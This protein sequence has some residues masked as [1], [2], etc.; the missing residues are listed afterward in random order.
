[1]QDIPPIP[2]LIRAEVP[3]RHSTPSAQDIPLRHSIQPL[4]TAHV[5]RPRRREL[6]QNEPKR[7]ARRVQVNIKREVN[8]PQVDRDADAQH[9]RGL[10]RVLR[11]ARRGVPQVRG[12]GHPDAPPNAVVVGPRRVAEWVYGRL[13]AVEHEDLREVVRAVGGGARDA[14][15]RARVL[16]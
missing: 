1:M 9:R 16:G 2:K 10:V 4:P 5:R 15:L 6:L 14:G 3:Y 12:D 7:R 13:A 8:V 11:G